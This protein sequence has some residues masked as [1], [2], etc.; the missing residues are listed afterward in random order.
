MKNLDNI[1]SEQ[2]KNIQIENDNF[3]QTF[4]KQV[5][6]KNNG[7]IEQKFDFI[8]NHVLL[9][10]DENDDEEEDIGQNN[11]NQ[12]T[13]QPPANPYQPMNDPSMMNPNMMNQDIS[14]EPY[15]TDIPEPKDF[16]Y[17]VKL[18]NQIE[19]LEDQKELY[20]K[21]G[22]GDKVNKY[23]QRIDRIL[24]LLEI[25][26][27]NINKYTK[28]EIAKITEEIDKFINSISKKKGEE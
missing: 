16:I 10:Q 22:K 13:Q 26:S 24:N 11:S 15:E 1:L 17:Y 25:L 7:L 6:E 23:I 3:N 12:V 8:K 2:E 19:F 5:F 9:E 4:I 14:D 18:S 20:S 21:Y 27:N 28:E